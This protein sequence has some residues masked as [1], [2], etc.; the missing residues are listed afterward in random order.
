VTP[1]DSQLIFAVSVVLSLGL[2][3]LLVTCPPKFSPDKT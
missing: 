1:P 2:C 3:V